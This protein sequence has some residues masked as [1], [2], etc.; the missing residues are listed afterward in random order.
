MVRPEY[1]HIS[2]AKEGMK[3]IGAKLY[4]VVPKPILSVVGAP[5]A[6]TQTQLS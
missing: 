6:I 5:L 2:Y 4:G 1:A 3:Q